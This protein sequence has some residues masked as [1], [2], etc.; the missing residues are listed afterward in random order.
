MTSYLS[1]RLWAGLIHTNPNSSPN[2]S[3]DRTRPGKHMPPSHRVVPT[4]GG[5]PLS[6]NLCLTLPVTLPWTDWSPLSLW[7]CQILVGCRWCPEG[8]L[9]TQA[10]S[11]L[12]RCSNLN[13]PRGK[14]SLRPQKNRCSSS[15]LWASTLSSSANLWMFHTLTTSCCPSYSSDILWK[16]CIR[17]QADLGLMRWLS[18]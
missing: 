12:R 15:G 13:G 16:R 14:W 2:W 7:G 8:L 10:V 1:L 9:Q 5:Y 3:R 4:M 18:R 6:S 11:A 17:K